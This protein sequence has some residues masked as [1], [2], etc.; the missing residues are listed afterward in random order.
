MKWWKNLFF[1]SP[2]ISLFIFKLQSFAY[3]EIC[4][5]FNSHPTEI[6]LSFKKPL[7]ITIL[8]NALTR[9]IFSK[10]TSGF[11]FC[12]VRCFL[13]RI[14]LSWESSSWNFGNDWVFPESENSL[15]IVVSGLNEW[16]FFCYMM[17]GWKPIFFFADYWRNIW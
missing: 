8:A 7:Y 16:N 9:K 2:T 3:D 15:K 11:L 4:I 13:F 17:E 1:K 14:Y 10:Q 12:F 6:C 5:K